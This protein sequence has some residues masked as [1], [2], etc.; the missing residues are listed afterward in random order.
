MI[1]AVLVIRKIIYSNVTM[2]DSKVINDGFIC[3]LEQKR[4]KQIQSTNT[5]IQFTMK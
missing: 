5:I 4:A 2:K 1:E 3:I